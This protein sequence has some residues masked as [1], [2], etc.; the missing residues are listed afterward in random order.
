LE[1]MVLVR[2]GG[3]EVLTT[4]PKTLTNQIGK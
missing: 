2:P 4:A 1:D 3:V